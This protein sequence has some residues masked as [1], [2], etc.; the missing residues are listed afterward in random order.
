MADFGSQKRHKLPTDGER[1]G[2]RCRLHR[3]GCGP[4]HGDGRGAPGML[5]TAVDV[6]DQANVNALLMPMVGQAEETTGAES[7]IDVGSRR[8]FRR[9]PCGR[10]CTRGQ[11]VVVI[12]SARPAD[13]AASGP[14]QLRH[15]HHLRRRDE[16]VP[17]NQRTDR[18]QSRRR[19]LRQGGYGQARQGRHRLLRT[20]AGWTKP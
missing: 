16:R 9:E 8:I 1:T 18:D 17:Q 11:Q 3:P 20:H 19:V 6:L 12:R 15:H 7:Q 5:V 10:V 4:A 13:G 14:G 2:Y